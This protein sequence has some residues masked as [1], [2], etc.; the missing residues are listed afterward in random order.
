MKSLDLGIADY[1]IRLEAKDESVLV[2]DK[3]FRNFLC[4]HK[5]LLD[6]DI[7]KIQVHNEERRI[8]SDA[9]KVYNAVFSAD[10][11]PHNEPDFWSVWKKG[12]TLYLKITF[13]SDASGK[14]ILKF[15]LD[16]FEWDL[17]INSDSLSFDALEYPLDSLILYYL[18]VINKDIM[19]HASGID[20]NGRGYLFSGISGKG[21]TTIAQLWE[22]K[23]GRVIHDDRLII[24]RKGQKY[25][26][27][28]TP[29]YNNEGPRSSNL[30]GIFIIEHGS[31]NIIT[32]L[33]GAKAVSLMMANC[34]QHNWER[35]IIKGLLESVTSLCQ[36]VPVYRLSFKPNESIIDHIINLNE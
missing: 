13:P 28:N 25:I 20:Y 21:K 19:V 14:A 33:N 35:N 27:H 23:G 5:N 31:E 12:N 2:A 22:N 17:W 18:T 36:S 8:P 4:T 7:V 34:I 11:F 3:R 24:R 29:V 30:D 1:K 6:E 26:M 9:E 10:D 32:P 16:S 15:S